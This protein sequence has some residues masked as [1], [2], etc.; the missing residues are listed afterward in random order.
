[1]KSLKYFLGFVGLLVLALIGFMV[2]T[3]T[4]RAGGPVTNQT[5]QT[6]KVKIFL[7]NPTDTDMEFVAVDREVAKSNVFETLVAETLTELI[8]GP[9]AT[10]K[11]QGLSAPFNDGT[12]VNYV[13]ISGNTLIVDFNDRFDFQMGGSMRVRA[14]FQMIDRTVRQ[15][16]LDGV[17]QLKLTVNRG[18]REAVLEP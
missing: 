12:V 14:I 1:M 16:P 13:K 7:T 11:L 9:T 5:H 17:T 18:E 2:Y 6:E 15:F 4:P 3:Y 10:E 8:K